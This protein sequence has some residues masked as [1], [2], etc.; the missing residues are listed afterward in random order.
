MPNA[1]AYCASGG[2][3]EGAWPAPGRAGR[4]DAAQRLCLLRGVGCC[5]RHRLAGGADQ[6]AFEG[7]GGGLHP[8]RQRR[9]GAGV[10]CRSLAADRR[11]AC[12][13][14]PR[15]RGA[16][17]A[18]N[19][20]GLWRPGRGLRRA[21]RHGELGDLAGM[22]GADRRAGRPRLADVLHVGH[23]RCAEGRA[24]PPDAARDGGGRRP[25]HRHRL[26]HQAEGRPGDPDE[27]ADVSLGA[28]FLRHGGVP[29]RLHHRARAALRCRRH[30]VADRAA[31][32]HAHAHGAD[33]VRAPAAAAG[34]GEE[35]ATTCRRCASSCMAPRRAR[36]MSSAR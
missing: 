22:A 12:R 25:R 29:A 23:D 15:V 1:P 4:D 34:R 28:E 9:A 2:R 33:H 7:G 11:R 5:R 17:A 6:L 36:R 20:R 10:P 8:R 31:S 14:S 21:G 27:R 24:S 32:C 16:D 30:A 13:G 3:A 19:R 18:G 35:P 26:R